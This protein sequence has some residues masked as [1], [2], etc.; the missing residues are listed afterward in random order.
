M[1]NT[2]VNNRKRKMKFDIHLKANFWNRSPSIIIKL[3]DNPL[4][5][6]NYFVN[7][8]KTITT[9]DA[10]C[11]E[12]QHQLII[13]RVNKSTKDT[14]VQGSKILK[15]STVDIIDVVIDNISVNPLLDHANFFPEYLEPWFSQ[16][17][18]IGKEPPE[19]YNYCRTLHHNGQWKLDFENPVH[20]WFFQNINVQI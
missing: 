6:V 20:I 5:T 18:L 1:L 3:D 2:C 9:F 14:V 4:E 8:E 17:K 7:N 19:S 15:D 16:Q 11:E 13:E 12:G 10:E